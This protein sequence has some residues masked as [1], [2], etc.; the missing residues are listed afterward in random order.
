MRTYGVESPRVP[1]SAAITVA[2]KAISQTRKDGEA[3]VS[4][5][6]AAAVQPSASAVQSAPAASATRGTLVNKYV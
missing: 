3:A 1:T 5:I 6:N 2:G 4:L